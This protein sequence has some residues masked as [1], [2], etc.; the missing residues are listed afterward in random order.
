MTEGRVLR[1]TRIAVAT[2]LLAFV[3]AGSAHAHVRSTAGFSDIAQRDGAGVRYVLSLEYDV[4]AA[5]SGLGK[6][7]N[8]R[9][10]AAVLRDRRSVLQRY[11]APRVRVYLDGAQ[12]E[13]T[14]E[15][16]RREDR[17]GTAY[18]RIVLDVGC[19]GSATGAYQ[20][21][22][23]VFGASD[24][25]VDDHTNVARYDLGGHRGTFVF[26]SGHQRLDVG[27]TGIASWAPRFVSL[28]VHHILGGIDHVLFLVALL[29]G[30]RGARSVVKLAST[31]TAA[32]SVTLALAT[33]G[34]VAV[35]AEI[36]EPLIALSI[37]YVAAENVIGGESRHRPAI[38]FGF[39]LLHGLGFA[40]ALSFTDGL[41]GQLLASLL[42]FNVGIELGQ[43]LVVLALFPLLLA[44]RRFAWSPVA[45]AGATVLAVAVGL[46]W[47][48]ER[49]LA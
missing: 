43:G 34:W 3:A 29:L 22:Y 37:A 32:H 21:V 30:A 11:L 15:D 31:F 33:L 45:H 47:F 9:R 12:C 36:V 13:S 10:Q 42:A 48:F 8:P 44:V 40:S 20:V 14:V 49:L 2:L 4:L 18:A 24:A 27:E 38:V 28:G 19:P 1:G 5:A 41:G 6:S 39:G 25:V 26:D 46:T 16:A 7:T 17:E 23:G 35:P